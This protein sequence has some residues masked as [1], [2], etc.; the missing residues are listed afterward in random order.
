[1]GAHGSVPFPLCLLLVSGGDVLPDQLG[2]ELVRDGVTVFVGTS[3][4]YARR[5]DVVEQLRLE[6]ESVIVRES[7]D[8]LA[9]DVRAHLIGRAR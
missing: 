7:L 8:A 2:K 1:M 6:D 5:F 9:D 4:G 3:T